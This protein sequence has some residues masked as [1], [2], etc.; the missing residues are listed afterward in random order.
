M[1]ISEKLKQARLA[2]G[3]TQEVSA[4]RIGVSRQSISNWEN[5][6]TYPDIIS[7]I[8]LS[9]V[10]DVSLDSLL[11]G[12]TEMKKHLK[13]STDVTKSNKLLS[14]SIVIAVWGAVAA[15]LLFRFFV[16]RP[17]D[18]LPQAI[19]DLTTHPIDFG[20]SRSHQICFGNRSGF[21]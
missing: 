15:A 17:R 7:V 21:S 11:K 2:A 19:I 12:D 14:V 20:H 6:K 16:G 3:L 4:E 18:F 10:Y 13:E 1:N 5:G 8:N 9:D